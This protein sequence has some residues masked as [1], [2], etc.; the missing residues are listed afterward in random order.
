MSIYE[1]KVCGSSF[2]SS[3][4]FSKHIRVKHF[5]YVKEYYDIYVKKDNEE[6]CS[7]CGKNTKFKGLFE[8]YL[9]ECCRSCSTIAYRKRLKESPE[10]FDSFSKKVSEN[11]SKIW[12]QRELTG[13]KDEILNKVHT[14]FLQTISNYTK[15]DRVKKFS[16]YYT[17]QEDKI[18]EL[19]KKQR[20]F[21]HSIFFSIV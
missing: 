12:K 4:K 3:Y 19:N 2:S 15:E 16:R 6:K 14:S 1:C 18:E 10:K 13:E 7:L 11:Q 8:G 5:R 21:F 9:N 20:E 17:M